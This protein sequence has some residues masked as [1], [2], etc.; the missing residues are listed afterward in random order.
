M[1][2]GRKTS[3]RNRKEQS[4]SQSFFVE[5]SVLAEPRVEVADS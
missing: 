2:Q 3:E 4:L 5:Y 1:R